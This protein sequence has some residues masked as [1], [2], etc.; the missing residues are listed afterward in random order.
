MGGY[1]K[2]LGWKQDDFS[3]QFFYT[4]AI[5]NMEVKTS[6]IRIVKRFFSTKIENG[7]LQV[8]LNALVQGD[9]KLFE[10][11]LRSIVINIISY[12]DLAVEP[13]RVYH[14]LVIGLLVWLTGSHEIKSNRE[15]G[16]GRYDIVIIPR[17]LDGIG[18]VIEFKTVDP[19]ENETPADALAAALKQIEDKKY[20]TELVE[21]NIKHI[22]KLAIA[23]NGKDVQVKEGI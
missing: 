9:I 17:N 8:M 10:K 16:Y 11:M 22:K 19:D 7:K 18:Y 15:S 4:L 5:P 6:Y 2:F 14:A 12:H 1:L 23:F 21:R 13:E 20:E 3:G